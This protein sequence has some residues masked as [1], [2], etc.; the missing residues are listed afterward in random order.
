[1]L[2]I[3]RILLLAAVLQASWL[4]YVQTL[5]APP[6]SLPAVSLDAIE[7]ATAEEIRVIQEG[8]QGTPIE[9]LQLAGIY[10]TWGLLPESAYC[11]AQISRED[12][13][14]NDWYYLGITLSRMGRLT[15]AA[16]MY[17]EAI[18]RGSSLAP[19]C[20]LMLGRDALRAEEPEK[21]EAFLKEAGNLPAAVIM[22]T[23]LLMHEGRSGEAVPLL[24][25]LLEEYP[26]SLSGH[27]K[28][29]WAHEQLGQLDKSYEHELRTLRSFDRF[30][31]HGV[32][33]EDDNDRMKL[34]GV[35]RLVTESQAAAELNDQGRAI[36]LLTQALDSSWIERFALQLGQIQLASGDAAAAQETALRCIESD[37]AS[38]ESLLLLGQAQFTAGDTSAAQQSWERASELPASRDVAANMRA[39][40]LLAKLH[41]SEGNEQLATWHSALASWQRGRLLFRQNDLTTALKEFEDAVE[42]LPQHE[43][44]LFMLGEVRFALDDVEGA[45][46]A[47]KTC[48]QHHPNCGRALQRLEQVARSQ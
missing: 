40:E 22:L 21:A 31:P 6:A 45:V 34:L 8:F 11:Y 38:A 46:R 41:E 20:W 1:M 28:L 25:S 12:L 27:Q 2:M 3:N 47:W 37:G 29:A 48:L 15:E 42:G 5:P 32:D 19:H 9:W 43:N 7:P 33:Q 35:A 4:L 24:Q 39:F 36:D 23:R 14:P 16:P 17:K 44:A 26:N 13:Q 18:S 30:S 10:R